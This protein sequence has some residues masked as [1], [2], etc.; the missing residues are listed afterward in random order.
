MVRRMKK[1]IIIYDVEYPDPNLE[2]WK[3]EIVPELVITDEQYRTFVQGYAPDWECR[4]SPCHYKNWLYITRSGFWL[5]KFR[6]EKQNDGLFHLTEHYTTEK[7]AGRNLLCEVLVEGYFQPS[8]I[9]VGMHY[10][11]IVNYQHLF[12]YYH[13]EEEN[14]YPDDDVRGKFWCGEK[15]FTE[16][17]LSIKE[18]TETGLEILKEASDEV[19]NKA[20]R[21]SPEQFGIIIYIETLYAKWCPGESLKWIFEY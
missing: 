11:N 21:Y 7:E 15:M 10:Q 5:K 17:R 9:E 13:F 19:R 12:K 16:G 20:L 14:P 6:F 2:D 18:W 3:P 1:S 4:Y 8:L